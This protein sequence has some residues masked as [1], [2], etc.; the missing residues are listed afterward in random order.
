MLT[1]Y[2]YFENLLENVCANLN[3]YSNTTMSYLINFLFYLQMAYI[4]CLGGGLE[5][6]SNNPLKAGA[7]WLGFSCFVTMTLYYGFCLSYPAREDGKR[8]VNSV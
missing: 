2:L 6:L 8:G 3:I 7:V 5:I 1:K 4:C